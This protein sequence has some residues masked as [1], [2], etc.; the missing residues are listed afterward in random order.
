MLYA[1]QIDPKDNVAVVSQDVPAGEQVHVVE[2][3]ADLTA[4]EFIRSGHK[5]AL[6][7]FKEG[8]TVVK[9]GIPIGRLKSDAPVG[10]LI[11]VNNVLDTTGELCSAY[12]K[13]YRAGG[14]T[15]RA[16]PRAGG[17]FGISN[18][19]VIFATSLQANILA[20]ALADETGAIWFVCDKN[21][22]E[23]GRISAFTRNVIEKTGRNPNIY[24]ALV[25][26]SEEDDAVNQA[27]A[28]E[29]R[30]AGKPVE[31]ISMPAQ[32]D[33]VCS[34]RRKLGAGIIE[35][36]Q[37]EIAGL[38]REEIPA[39]G[40][41][42]AV[43]CG[44]SD[45]TTALAGNPTLGLAADLLVKH[46]GYV[47]MDEWGGFPGSDHLLAGHAATRRIGL[48][49]VEKV[50]ETRARYL[51]D[52]GKP[53]EE[54]N[55]YPSN[56]EGGITTLVE[57]STGNIKKAGSSLIQGILKPGDRPTIP[58]VYLQD[59]PCGC[60]LSTAAY[61]ALS[62][63]HL[64]VFVTGRGYVYQELPYMLSIRMTGNPETFREH[65][66][67]LL[68]F[69]A[70]TVIE[71]KPMQEAGQELFDYILAV[72]SGDEVPKSEAAKNNAFEFFYYEDE[73]NDT[74]CRRIWDYK[75]HLYEKIDA[76]KA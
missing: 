28:E 16:F 19:I 5:I 23:D 71:G 57:K 67:Y 61:A 20:E 42:M 45:W 7:D 37:K 14:R 47:I 26:G 35:G 53:V 24:A 6:V 54:T 17:G 65:P 10:S 74:I 69:N 62:G 36:W 2:T 29:I 4:A 40:L 39:E 43:H 44:G 52:T 31:Y 73:F 50:E 70:G 25:I 48:E 21:R 12:V 55:P 51:R 63:C 38:K 3:G 56:I 33:Y 64:N 11:H 34:R 49:I 76:V 1:I 75:K 32:Q 8:D 60:P 27:I 30:S 46:G 58:G 13:Q 9:Y 41:T 68:D 66:E 18:Y 59:Q 15:I 22:L 72:A